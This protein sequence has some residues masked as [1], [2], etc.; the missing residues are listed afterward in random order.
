MQNCNAYEAWQKIIERYEGQ[1][2]VTAMALKAQAWGRKLNNGEGLTQLC[3]WLTERFQTLATTPE[4]MG[5]TDKKL[6]LVMAIEKN[7]RYERIAAT[8]RHDPSILTYTQAVDMVRDEVRYLD[9]LH[10]EE[11]LSSNINL[12]DSDGTGGEA[13]ESKEQKRI[14]KLTKQLAKLQQKYARGRSK[15]QGRSRGRGRGR[16]RGRQR[17]ETDGDTTDDEGG[18]N[19]RKNGDYKCYNC[20]KKGHYARD[21]WHDGEHDGEKKRGRGK[22]QEVEKEVG[23]I[24]RRSIKLDINVL[25]SHLKEASAAANFCCGDAVLSGERFANKNTHLGPSSQQTTAAKHHNVGPAN[26]HVPVKQVRFANIDPDVPD[27]V[28]SDSSDDEEPE[29]SMCMHFDKEKPVR[30]RIV[31]LDIECD[32]N[33]EFYVEKALTGVNSSFSQYKNSSDAALIDSGASGHAAPSPDFLNNLKKQPPDDAPFY[34]ASGEK[35]EV[36]HCGNIGEIDNVVCL[37][38]LKSVIISVGQ[39]C[40]QFRCRIIFDSDKFTC[41]TIIQ[42]APLWWVGDRCQMVC[43]TCL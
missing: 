34:T 31:S 26:K 42:T 20:G 19:S 23:A 3:D 38:D 22:P 13:K 6:V 24:S 40:D 15:S 17:D 18:R 33:A 32:I 30:K 36:T 1:S 2:T 5:E 8:I 21:C 14:A 4:K 28:S 10:N 7:P 39:L 29:N 16:S 43:T 11:K 41:T 25:T 12:L 35:L 9:V 37:P 27:L